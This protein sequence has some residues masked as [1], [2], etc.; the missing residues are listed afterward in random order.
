MG[1]V[2]QRVLFILQNSWGSGFIRSVFAVLE[3]LHKSTVVGDF[4]CT[5]IFEQLLSSTP[6]GMSVLA[7]AVK[8]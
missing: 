7:V 3:R 4:S 6:Y 8:D 5:A 1:V 2:N